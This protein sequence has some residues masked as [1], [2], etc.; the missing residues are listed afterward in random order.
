MGHFEAT[1]EPDACPVDPWDGMAMSLEFAT[2][3]G[4]VRA[5]DFLATNHSNFAA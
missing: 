1:S 5:V 2:A 3:Q 4:L